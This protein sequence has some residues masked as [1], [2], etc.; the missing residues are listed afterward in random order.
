MNRV[1]YINNDTIHILHGKLTKQDQLKI[2]NQETIELPEG[3]VLNGVIINRENVIEQLRIHRKLLQNATILFNS[4]N[5]IIKKMMLPV[6]KKKDTLEVVKKEFALLEKNE[7]FIYDFHTSMK[8]RKHTIIA[9]GVPKQFV[10]SYVDVFQEAGITIRR[11]DSVLNHVIQYIETCPTFK[12]ENFVLNMVEKNTM[13][14]LLFEKGY[15]MLNN[16]HRIIHE[17]NSEDY[18]RE[19]FSALSSMNQFHR[20]QKSPHQ[21]TG[22][23]YT[24]IGEESFKVLNRLMQ[25]MENG[26]MAQPFVI[27]EQT[28]TEGLY[29][30]MG[31]NTSKEQVNFLEALT[32]SNKSY[33]RDKKWFGKVLNTVLLAAV[34][35]VAFNIINTNNQALKNEIDTIQNELVSPAFIQQ[36]S[37]VRELKKESEDLKQVEEQL[38]EVI[39]GVVS[40]KAIDGIKLNAMYEAQGHL[41]DIAYVRYNYEG[42]QIEIKG[43]AEGVHETQHF[44]TRLKD[45]GIFETIDYS[46]YI[47]KGKN[48][49]SFVVQAV[50]KGGDEDDTNN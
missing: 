6:L 32:R 19:L 36:L 13:V 21:I 9:C 31:L 15:Y 47:N 41:I 44:V 2:K 18:G 1:I 29:M 8:T 37:E 25:M 49:Y 7:D 24:G 3:S 22:S 50:L 35:G 42:K 33:L 14:S 23:Y 11:I 28:T 16:R 30:A 38:Q 26:I 12:E 43:V 27:R 20:A 39:E 48:T 34:I 46:G 45:T 10:Q 40:H 17:I 5:I 4:S